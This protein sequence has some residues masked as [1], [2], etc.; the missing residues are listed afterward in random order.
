VRALVW[1]ILAKIESPATEHVPSNRDD[2]PD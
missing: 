1:I 2:S